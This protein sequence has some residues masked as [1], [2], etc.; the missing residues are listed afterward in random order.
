MDLKS[1]GGDDRNA[2]YIPLHHFLKPWTTCICNKHVSIDVLKLLKKMKR[3]YF[4]LNSLDIYEKTKNI[5]VVP[6]PNLW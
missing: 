6:F 2:Q 5:Y 1:G 3:K 4:L